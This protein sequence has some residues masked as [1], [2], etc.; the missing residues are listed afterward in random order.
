MLLCIAVMIEP[1]M[2]VIPAL[3]SAELANH[4][5]MHA[6]LLTKGQSGQGPFQQPVVHNSSTYMLRIDET[7]RLYYCPG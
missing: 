6:F 2:P 3:A 5:M 1:D 7:L 4:W